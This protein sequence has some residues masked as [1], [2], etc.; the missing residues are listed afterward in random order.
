MILKWTTRKEKKMSNLLIQLTEN[1]KRLIFAL[2]LVFILVF[3]LIGYLGML[4]VKIMKWQGKRM[5]HMCSDV[6]TTFVITDKKS[7]FRY[8]RKK[9]NRLFYKQSWFPLLIIF[10]AAIILVIGEATYKNPWHYN[11]FSKEDGFATLL[12]IWDFKDPDSWTTVFGLKVLAKWPPLDATYGQPTFVIAAWRG[13]IFVPTI[14]IGG[15]WYLISVQ[16][17]IARMLAIRKIYDQNVA[18]DL[19]NFNQ[20]EA[21]AKQPMPQIDNVNNNEQ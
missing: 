17:F 16:A 18:G 19:N 1:D 12:F 7:L 10:I 20:K 4:V 11:P 14:F 15:I 3:V 8:A 21:L 2:L 13:Y 5:N 9:N 6:L